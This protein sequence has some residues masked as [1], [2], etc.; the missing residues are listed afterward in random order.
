MY[1]KQL[2]S[3]KGEI[4]ASGWCLDG[5]AFGG[6]TVPLLSKVV[7]QCLAINRKIEKAKYM[8]VFV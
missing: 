1:W 2:Q 8:L 6:I 3:E 5:I 7:Y 4:E